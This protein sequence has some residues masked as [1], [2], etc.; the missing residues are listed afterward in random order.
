L[1]DGVLGPVGGI[2]R[3]L[4]SS[5][6]PID[7]RPDELQYFHLDAVE[8]GGQQWD[9]GV[10]TAWMRLA[11]PVLP[12]REVS[13]LQRV[14]AAAD[15]MNGISSRLT[16]GEWVFINPDLTITVHRAAVG[17][18]I[19]VRAV[20]RLDPLGVGTAEADLFDTEGRIGHAVQNLLVEPAG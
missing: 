6:T 4:A 9:D 8:W 2:E 5:T 16:F 19:G 15:F 20:T 3:V 7:W 14:A 12:G 1:P 18:W 11:V 10:I 13:S 17:E